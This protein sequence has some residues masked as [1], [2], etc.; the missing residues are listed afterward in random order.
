METL[1]APLTA[2]P[3]EVFGNVL[4]FWAGEHCPIQTAEQCSL[5]SCQ[6]TFEVTK[7]KSGE[8]ALLPIKW[9]I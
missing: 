8:L 9:F 5:L 6:L 3:V 2:L 7:L 4:A 1:W